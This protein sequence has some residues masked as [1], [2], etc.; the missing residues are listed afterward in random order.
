[1]A[2][3]T[4]TLTVEQFLALPEEQQFRKELLGGE[5]VE[6]G[7]AKA[8]HEIMKGLICEALT[9]FAAT[10]RAYFVL[11]ES[12]FRVTDRDACV[13]DVS[14]VDRQWLATVDPE[15][16]FPGA[17]ILAVE[18]VSSESASRIAQKIEIYLS[19]GAKVVWVVYPERKLVDVHYPG[20]RSRRLHATDTLTE[21][22]L[23]DGFSLLLKDLFAF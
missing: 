3:G 6:M 18:V 11:S 21:P 2:A 8:I 23:L 15:M 19:G 10:N 17:P 12:M 14:L 9:I 22:E 7:N 5:V 4:A 1:M 13:P 16:R 20:G